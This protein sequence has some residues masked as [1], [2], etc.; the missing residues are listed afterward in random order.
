MFGAHWIREII[1]M[2][3]I[4]GSLEVILNMPDHTKNYVQNIRAIEIFVNY[5]MESRILQFSMTQ[6]SVQ[7]KILLS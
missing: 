3:M 6:G 4:S 5:V 7:M 1:W 2:T